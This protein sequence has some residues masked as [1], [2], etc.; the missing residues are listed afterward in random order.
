ME[1]KYSCELLNPKNVFSISNGTVI[2]P[3][4]NNGES[5]WPENES[6][7]VCDK[8]KSTFHFNDTVLPPLKS[9]E[10]KDIK[11][12]MIIPSGLAWRTYQIYMNFNVKGKNYGNEIMAHMNR[13]SGFRNDFYKKNSENEYREEDILDYYRKD[14]CR[15]YDA[16][17][18]VYDYF[19][20]DYG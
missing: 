11:L 7:L 9:G 18:R 17:Q 6:K 5:D 4:K 16:H 20:S 19:R 3:L 15:D 12:E 2:I 8:T 14:D 1:S 10:S 13:V